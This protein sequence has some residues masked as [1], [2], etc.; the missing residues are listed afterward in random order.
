[1]S[2]TATLG[3]YPVSADEPLIGNFSGTGDATMFN[4]PGT[5]LRR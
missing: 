3:L 4:L 5:R 1:L 2:T